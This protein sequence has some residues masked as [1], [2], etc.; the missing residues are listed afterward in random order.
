[1]AVETAIK[2]AAW[3]AQAV[4]SLRSRDSWTGRIHVHKLLV[5]LYL[6]KLAEP[7]FD[8]EIYRYGPYSFELDEVIRQM[9]S[10]GHLRKEFPRKGYGPRYS[11]SSIGNQDLE[12]LEKPT[13][14]TI[15]RAAEQIKGFTSKNLEL[16]ATCWWVSDKENL[17]SDDAIV[18]RVHILKP[19]YDEAEIRQSL[20]RFKEL[21]DHL[22]DARPL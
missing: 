2:E 3:V 1:M 9:T 18:H 20:S 19:H 14:D 11:L 5:L 6:S 7:P 4:Q 12:H 16:T 13:R 10:L 8:F 17:D 21:K 22:C 15:D